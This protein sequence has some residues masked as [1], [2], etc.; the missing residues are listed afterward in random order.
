[1][2][3]PVLVIGNKKYSSWSLRPWLLLKQGEVDFEEVRVAL[4][5]QD[6]WL[7]LQQWSPTFKVPVLAHGPI[8]VWDSLAICEYVSE[9][10]LDGKGWPADVAARAH[11]R[12]ITAE[13]H[14]GFQALR[15]QWPMNVCY[16]RQQP[17]TPSL[18]SDIARIEA[19]WTEC[20]ARSGGPFLF[21]GFSIA[22]TMFAPVVLRFASYQPALSAR[23]EG[24]MRTVQALPALQQWVAAGSKETEI[25]SEDEYDWLAA[26]ALLA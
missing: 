8:R 26:Q 1:M 25:I 17:V 6:T 23:S 19:I 7:H 16:H 24:Y 10:L 9:Q 12:A 14:S 3:R 2:T 4:F 5:Q 21:G 15:S 22:D 18:A 13:M 20:L 11:A